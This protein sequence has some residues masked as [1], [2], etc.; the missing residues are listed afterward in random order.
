MR[1]KNRQSTDPFPLVE[2]GQAD[3]LGRHKRKTS[4]ARPLHR[5]VKR[6]PNT[7]ALSSNVQM[8]PVYVLAHIVFLFAYGKSQ[9][10]YREIHRGFLIS[11]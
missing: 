9:L 6:D 8:A 4:H 11:T 2:Q 5:L 10:R 1:N 7:A 3:P